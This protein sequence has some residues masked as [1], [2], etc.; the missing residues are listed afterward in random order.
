[1]LIY[2]HLMLSDQRLIWR[3]LTQLSL[4]LNQFC[5]QVGVASL[6]LC[7][8]QGAALFKLHCIAPA[9]TYLINLEAHS[10]HIVGLSSFTLYLSFTSSL[11]L[12]L[13]CL[14]LSPPASLSSSFFLL[15][16]HLSL[17]LPSLSFSLSVLL[18]G[19]VCSLNTEHWT[20][21]LKNSKNLV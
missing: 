13:L 15:Y 5:I 9:V 17:S 18:S 3:T 4:C 2:W 8:N 16:P 11:S 14:S 19:K 10:W 1:M 12:Y 20:H 7:A 6:A 21:T